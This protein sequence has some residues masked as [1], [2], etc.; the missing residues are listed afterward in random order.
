MS[1]LATD[2]A[3]PFVE[4]GLVAD[5][6]AAVGSRIALRASR[7]GTCGRIEF[8]ALADCPAEGAAVEEVELGPDAV[9]HGF[10]EVLHAPPGAEVDVPYT[11]AVAAFAGNLAVLGRL[12]SHVPVDGLTIG[13]PV[14]VVMSTYRQGRT[15]AFRPVP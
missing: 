10:T 4:D 11:L 9:L 7:C 13:D 12:E 3:L 8:P 2:P 6:E 5:P 14:E 15:Y 1:D